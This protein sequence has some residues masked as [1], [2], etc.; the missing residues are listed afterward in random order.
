MVSVVVTVVGVGTARYA[1]LCPPYAAAL[2]IEASTKINF[3][4]PLASAANPSRVVT[5][6]VQPSRMSA[7]G[8]ATSAPASR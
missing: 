2:K 7:E 4:Q 1:R 5:G 3:P 8:S 6:G